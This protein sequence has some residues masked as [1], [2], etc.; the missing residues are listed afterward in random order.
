[1]VAS[2]PQAARFLLCHMRVKKSG[3]IPPH[4]KQV[5]LVLVSLGYLPPKIEVSN[6]A[7]SVQ[8]TYTRLYIQQTCH[9]DHTV[10][11][12]RRNY[13]NAVLTGRHLPGSVSDI[14]D[15]ISRFSSVRTRSYP[16]PHLTPSNCGAGARLNYTLSILCNV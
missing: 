13:L 1:M 15:S 11:Q 5:R 8:I 3:Q 9:T 16:S 14:V 2:T 6:T 10:K 12:T 7:E 4:S